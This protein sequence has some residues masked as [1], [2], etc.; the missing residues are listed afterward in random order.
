[1][2]TTFAPA[3]TRP[4]RMAV[5]GVCAGLATHLGWRESTV[6]LVVI[7]LTVLGGAGIL[8]YL[9]LWA[10]APVDEA[11]GPDDAVS[12]S[13]PVAAILLGLGAVAAIVAVTL[14]NVAAS[15]YAAVAITVILGGG[16]VAWNLAFD[17]DDDIRSPRYRILVRSFGAALLTITGVLLLLSRGARPDAVTA[18]LAVFMIVVGVAVAA[19]PGIVRLWTELLA[20]RAGRVREEQ[21]AEIA[22]HL[23]DSV[24]QT[25]ALIQ[26][27]AGPSSEVA[28][29]ARAQERELRD[30]LFAGSG[31]VGEDLATELRRV[32][33]AIELDYPARVEVVATGEPAAAHTALVAAAR[34]AMLNAARHAGG[35]VSVYLETSP[36]GI[37]VFIRDR[38]P[39]IDLATLPAD[40][41]GIRESIIGRMSRAGGSATVA[42]GAGGGTEVHLHLD[43]EPG[44]SA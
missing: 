25:L 10:F 24:L 31:P 26:N 42:P 7:G 27:R 43:T 11:Q 5:A 4:R 18:V 6:R 3:L 9:W 20:E 15:P 22:A 28:R 34:E 40:R 39:G 38:G 36:D 32:A 33:A 1:M 16:A 29:L 17:R 19:L 21:R 12:R 2:T 14:A 8:L 35:E 23:H 44:G 37:D 41:L 13:V 30:W